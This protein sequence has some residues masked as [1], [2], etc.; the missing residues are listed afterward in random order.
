MWGCWPLNVPLSPELSL[1]MGWWWILLKCY[2]S[3]E[4][5]VL[6][7]CVSLLSVTK[8]QS[9]VTYASYKAK[10]LTPSMPTGPDGILT[11]RYFWSPGRPDAVQT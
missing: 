5:C 10:Y 1:V 8:M 11:Y 4:S 3:A 9:H 6:G 7:L 2:E